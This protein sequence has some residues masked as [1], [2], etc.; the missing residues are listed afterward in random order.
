MI[1][2]TTYFHNNNMSREKILIRT[3]WVSTI[4]NAILSVS[5]IVVGLLSGSL[6]VIGDGIDSATDV[7]ISV[8]MIFT[9]RLMN[10]PPSKKYVFGYEK[11]ESIATKV[12]SLVIFYA[13]AQMLVSSVES[14]FSNETKEIPS[15]IA[16]YVTVFSIVGKLL[17]STYQYKQGK[18]TSLNAPP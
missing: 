12:L 15:A 7:V 18:K 4:G 14:I 8:V 13:G 5:K 2:F 1:T 3:S 17:L 9:A 16:I 10:K 6:A 11:A